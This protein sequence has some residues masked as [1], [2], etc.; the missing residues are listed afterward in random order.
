[1]I[2]MVT[3]ELFDIGY[4][5]KSEA[6]GARKPRNPKKSLLRSIAWPDH[7]RAR[8]RSHY[9]DLIWSLFRRVGTPQRRNQSPHVP[10]S[11]ERSW[12]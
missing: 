5:K 11:A 2:V 8:R 10:T 9:S 12:S 3:P 6:A 7:T 1:M 4:R